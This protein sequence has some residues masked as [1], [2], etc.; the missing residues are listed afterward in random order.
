MSL[1]MPP[2]F[3]FV[4]ASSAAQL[5][6]RL[7]LHDG[8]LVFQTSH[9]AQS[10]AVALATH[11]RW[12][13]MGIVWVEEGKPMVLDAVSPV[14]LT[15]LAAWQARGTGGHIA[16]RRLSNAD[17]IFTPQVVARMKKL[18][19]SWLSRPY[20][21]RFEWSDEALY[22]SELVYKLLDRAAGIQVGR[23]RLAR[24]FNLA[25]PKVQALMKK[26]FGPGHRFNPEERVISPE[27]MIVHA[28]LVTVFEN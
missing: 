14:R 19:R 1:W 6:D 11:S 18:G 21:V 3:L 16:I 7:L 17:Q 27:D 22:C 28:S 12:T 4:L 9:S 25:D 20:D 24:E 10:K 26:R 2:T 15:P 5:P 8:D 23:L 13:H